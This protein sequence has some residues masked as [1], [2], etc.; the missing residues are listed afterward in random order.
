MTAL[1]AEHANYRLA[2]VGGWCGNDGE[3]PRKRRRV[4][5]V[6]EGSVVAWPDGPLGRL[7][8]VNPNGGDGLSHPVYRSGYGL[9]VAVGAKALEADHE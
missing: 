6:A 3:E 1:L 8:N 5:L 9:A 7:V 4:R 2:T